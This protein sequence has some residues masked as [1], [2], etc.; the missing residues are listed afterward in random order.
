MSWLNRYLNDP[1]DQSSGYTLPNKEETTDKNEIKQPL[2]SWNSEHRKKDFLDY[3]QS[4]KQALSI[5][6]CPICLTQL[7]KSLNISSNP[8]KWIMV[9]SKRD[10]EENKQCEFYCEIK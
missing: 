3:A 9:C 7:K 4:M 8:P 10:P 1:I 2:D 5:E 6:K